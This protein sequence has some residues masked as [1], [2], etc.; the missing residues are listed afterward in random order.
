MITITLGTI[1]YSF[2]RAINWISILLERE[3][4]KEPVFVQ[5]GVS[6][7]SKIADHPLVTVAP[8]VPFSEFVSLLENSRLI[9]AHAGQGSTRD[10]A[11]RR[12]N[13]V[14]IPRFSQFREHVDDHQLAF[15]ESVASC[16]IRYCLTFDDLAKAIRA[17]SVCL[18]SNLFEGPYLSKY[19][20]QRYPPT[21]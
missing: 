3:V 15:A 16:G 17:P 2:D 13:F 7:V 12:A 11:S 20:I 9:I 14:L 19:L 8:K 5:Y 6:D 4:I 1:P 18:K 10:L 21:A